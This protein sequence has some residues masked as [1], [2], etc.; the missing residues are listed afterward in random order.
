MC[1][2]L[3]G[4]SVWADVELAGSWARIVYCAQHLLSVH[5]HLDLLPWWHT[6]PTLGLLQSLTDEWCVVIHL[7]LRTLALDPARTSESVRMWDG[8]VRSCKYRIA[9]Y[10]PAKWICSTLKREKMLM[11]VISTVTPNLWSVM[12]WLWTLHH[13]CDS[14]ELFIFFG[15]AKH[16]SQW[17]KEWQ[18]FSL[19]LI[20]T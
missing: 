17:G 3:I 16:E 12:L 7:R 10:L 2:N 19:E 14:N 8:C 13:P 4:S 9:T 20:G 5:Q 6:L 15:L 11:I 1:P 18:M